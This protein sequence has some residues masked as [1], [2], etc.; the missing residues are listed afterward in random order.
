MSSTTSTIPST[1]N[2]S[3]TVPKPC[4]CG[5]GE[6][7]TLAKQTDRRRGRVKG[8][9]LRFINGHNTR[10]NT[11]EQFEAKLAPPNGDG[12]ILWTA[13]L[14]NHGY[15]NYHTGMAGRTRKAHRFAYERIHGPLDARTHLH[16]ICRTPRC[17]NPDHL[18]PLLPS[19]HMGIHHAEDAITA[20]ILEGGDF[21]RELEALPETDWPGWPDDSSIGARLPSEVV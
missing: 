8:E 19:E 17:C 7:T 18:R 15:G 12:C 14:D 13:A 1:N 21:R 9:P 2:P 11:A 5:C 6:P 16:H 20:A 4:E 10:K 3:T